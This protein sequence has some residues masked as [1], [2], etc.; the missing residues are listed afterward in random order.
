MQR[1]TLRTALIA[2]GAGA[3]AVPFLMAPADATPSANARTVL[4]GTQ[5]SW[6]SSARQ[7]GTP[8]SSS[9][10]TFQAVLPLRNAAG[11]EALADAVSNPK[12]AQYKHYLTAK[13]FNARFAPSAGT[14]KSVSSYLS[15]QG[16]T[17]K[18]AAPGNRW[19]SVS[20]TVSQVNKAFGTTLRNYSY[21]GKVLR[22]PS[23]AASVPQ[24]IRS[25]VMTFTGLD[26]SAALAHPLS[27]RVAASTPVQKTP[28]AAAPAPSACSNYW[29]QHEQRLP[30]AYAGKDSFPTYICGYVGDQLQS[31]YGTKSALI[32]GRDGHGVTVGIIDAYGSPT[33]LSDLT[34]YSNLVG[35]PAP[36]KGQYSE[37]LFTPFDQQAECGGE[38]GWNGE[39]T[40][41]VEAVH[42]MAP[43]AK[44]F[45]AGATNCG[46]GID[47]A[48]NWMIQNQKADLISNSYG[49]AGEDITASEINAQ[50]S[51]FVQ[52]AAQGIGLY[53]S[54]GD[55]G[56][57]AGATGVVQPD[58]PSSDP[59]V[60]GVGGTSIG[61]DA[62]GNRLW[63][64]SYGVFIDRVLPDYSDYSEALPGEFNQGG[65]GGTSTLFKQPAYQKGVVPASLSKMYGN[66]AMRTV[67]DVSALG[68]P[69]TG[70]LVGQT[71]DGVFG[72]YGIGGTSLS[73][74]L[75]AGIQALVSQGLSAPIGFANPA[76]YSLSGSK[77]Y[78]DITPPRTPVAISNP[79][80]TYLGT[81]DH[82]TSLQTTHGYDN[83][84]GIGSPNGQKFIKGERAVA[85][86]S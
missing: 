37:K 17:V 73:C 32:N 84:T 23:R 56:D 14:V 33:M 44:I 24:S 15:K 5:P 51:M 8:S 19:I 6:A 20:G 66:K 62:A 4:A 80:G 11:A 64:H 49:Y 39:Q 50:H 74:P 28:A 54:T 36:T 69:Y 55:R 85:G 16:F 38:A 59:K 26:Q 7:V 57:E 13:Q 68:D 76:L 45:Y 70:F 34:Q 42:S 58:Y 40:L 53:Y 43:G 81:L 60:T 9:T 79:S 18:G 86:T 82:D 67:P 72:T 12:S 10:I 35:L 1:R 41:D 30:A 29:D 71:E 27:H 47:A 65:G 46:D 2:V 22:A 78:N 61:I 63:E 21:K 31:A 83:A 77:A 3:L 48:L 75:F 52:A 25:Q